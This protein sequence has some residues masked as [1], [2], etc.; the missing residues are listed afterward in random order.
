MHIKKVKREKWGVW[1]S[2]FM[3][4]IHQYQLFLFDL[5]GLLVNT[6]EVHFQAYRNS[7]ARHGYELKWS[8]KEYCLNAHYGPEKLRAEINR[9]I[10]GMREEWEQLYAVKQAE[11]EKLLEMDEALLMP[12]AEILLRGLH[13]AGI[14]SCVVTNSKEEFVSIL[15]KK[16]PA[17]NLITHW[18]T[19]KDYTHPKPHP[20][21]YQMAIQRFAKKGDKVIGFEDT[22]RGI[23]ALMQTEAK[24]VMIST[25]PYPDMPSLLEA[26]VQL[27]PSLEVLK[28]L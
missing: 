12:G 9:S 19:R 8:F 10:P 6:E 4:W 20:E 2:F 11:V 26:G 27:F 25:T 24:A 28:H 23:N 18:I 13:K 5:D 1:Y 21:S 22:P 7:L 17:L 16:N 15:K 3:Q 14:P